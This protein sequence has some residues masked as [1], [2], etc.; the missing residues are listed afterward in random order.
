MGVDIYANRG[1][2]V[3][4]SELLD[5]I[6]EETL[7]RVRQAI[8]GCVESLCETITAPHQS[9]ELQEWELDARRTQAL[10][11]AERLS[12]LDDNS[13][14]DQVKEMLESLTSGVEDGF[15]SYVENGEHAVVLWTAILGSAFPALPHPESTLMI[16]SPRYQG[17]DL[18]VGEILYVFPESEC[19]N[20]AKTRK[21]AALDAALGRPVPVLTWT[22]HSV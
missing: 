4:E 21:G 12:E 3:S 10:F 22:I 7:P 11:F 18:P 2:V 19:V 8:M 1:I 17:Q 5:L 6:T 20:Y 9:A 16:G 14:A 15:D 13:D